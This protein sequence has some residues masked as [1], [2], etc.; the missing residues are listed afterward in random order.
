MRSL[1]PWVLEVVQLYKYLCI[2]SKEDQCVHKKQDSYDVHL[3]LHSHLRLPLLFD[4]IHDAA[5]N[6]RVSI[7]SLIPV[8][9]G[10]AFRDPRDRRVGATDYHLMSSV[11]E[12]H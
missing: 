7:V 9:D 3:H 10:T 2:V 11:E 5:T 1:K 8:S 6:P 4:I 12:I